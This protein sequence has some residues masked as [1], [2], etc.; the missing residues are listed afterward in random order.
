MNN[1]ECV[2]LC[3]NSA[4][5]LRQQHVYE[6]PQQH[7]VSEVDIG[8]QESRCEKKHLLK[9]DLSYIYTRPVSFFV[10]VF[11]FRFFLLCS[12]KFTVG[13]KFHITKNPKF[14]SVSSVSAVP[15]RRTF[16]LRPLLCF[17]C[18]RRLS[19]PVVTIYLWLTLTSTHTHT[20]S[21]THQVPTDAYVLHHASI[22][23]TSTY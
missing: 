23:S 10:D 20:H 18:V 7:C 12:A 15:L 2:S 22:T 11:V 8:W 13:L 6:K 4:C 21:C 5:S 1:F 16:L 17:F 3:V 19:H 9:A 14:T